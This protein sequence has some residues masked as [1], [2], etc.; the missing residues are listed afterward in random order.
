MALRNLRKQFQGGAEKKEAPPKLPDPKPEEPRAGCGPTPG[1]NPGDHDLTREAD[2]EEQ[3]A[4]AKKS[5]PPAAEAM[6]AETREVDLEDLDSGTGLGEDPGLAD[7]L[8][9]SDADS[10]SEDADQVL[11]ELQE[12]LD[13]V[14]DDLVD[15]LTTE[16]DL[17]QTPEEEESTPPIP[18]APKKPLRTGATPKVEEPEEDEKKLD[19]DAVQS[20]V[21]A[22]LTKLLAPI[23]AKL[24][25]L[26]KKVVGLEIA[27]LGED[28]EE[29]EEP[30]QEVEDLKERVAKVEGLK[31]SVDGLES[32]IK[33]LRDLIDGENGISVSIGL[34]EN[35]TA[36][37]ESQ[38]VSS[39]VFNLLREDLNDQGEMLE[40]L[41]GPAGE[42]LESMVEV[43]EDVVCRLVVEYLQQ[44]NPDLS[45]FVE[46]H[47]ETRVLDQ[48]GL[49]AANPD[50][51]IQDQISFLHYN[52]PYSEL[53]QTSG[54]DSDEFRFV[55]QSSERVIRLAQDFLR[56]SQEPQTGDS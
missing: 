7:A 30:D 52:Q 24:E 28:E 51:Y 3:K 49:V 10:V 40:E 39:E 33:G 4:L 22:A 14:D 21:Q 25:E 26:G 42:S 44:E 36:V 15:P 11:A 16:A 1:N 37:L 9:G 45:T 13:A 12:A 50:N 23:E 54:A 47:G 27:F 19:M 8:E 41:T 43:H 56:K 55:A 35:R 48:L 31:T 20:V 29:D 18:A 34:L 53:E 17:S 46:K 38:A 32:D 5:R 2:V 6:A